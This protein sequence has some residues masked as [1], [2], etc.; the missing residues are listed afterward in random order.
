MYI[1]EPVEYTAEELI[2][3]FPDKKEA[4]L[5]EIQGKPYIRVP[6]FEWWTNKVVCV[7]IGTKKVL[8]L[9]V[10]PFLN[11]KLPK[12]NYYPTAPIP[13]VALNVYNV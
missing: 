1:G 11:L 10:N 13:Y 3:M 12:L 5:Q 4:I 8:N 6:C 7:T 9:K 2:E